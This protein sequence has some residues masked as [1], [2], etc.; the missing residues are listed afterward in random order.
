MATLKAGLAIEFGSIAGEAL[1]QRFLSAECP[2]FRW[3]ARIEERC[4]VT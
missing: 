2:E 4:D 3:D 1:A